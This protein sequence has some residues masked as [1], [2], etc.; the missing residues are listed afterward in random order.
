[1]GC[2]DFDSYPPLAYQHISMCIFIYYNTYVYIYTHTCIFNLHIIL[3]IHT[4]NYNCI[5]IYIW[6]HKLQTDTAHD[7]VP[8]LDFS[9]DLRAPE[10]DLESSGE[11]EADAGLIS[12]II[13]A[14][15]EIWRHR[16]GLWRKESRNGLCSPK[17]S[18]V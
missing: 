5:Y 11:T 3:Y 15:L 13:V 10:T 16:L 18:N 8:A 14:G 9:E 2:L 7:F 4:H 17:E 12:G 6:I 1:M